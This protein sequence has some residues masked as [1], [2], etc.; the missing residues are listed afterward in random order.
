MINVGDMVLCITERDL[1]D[2]EYGYSGDFQKCM[3]SPI[4]VSL[5]F[6]KAVEYDGPRIEEYAS[7]HCCWIHHS[8]LKKLKVRS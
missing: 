1:M 7:Y 2:S 6:D 3:I 5:D 4:R 8:Y